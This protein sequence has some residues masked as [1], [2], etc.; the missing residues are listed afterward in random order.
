MKQ[1]L[2]RYL[3]NNY[4]YKQ[5]APVYFKILRGEITTV[6]QIADEMMLCQE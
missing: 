1:R 2:I 5:S 6:E 4:E 3:R